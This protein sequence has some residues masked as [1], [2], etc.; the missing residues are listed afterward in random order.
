MQRRQQLYPTLTA[1][2]ALRGSTLKALAIDGVD[3]VDPP[4]PSYNGGHGLMN[5]RTSVERLN[6]D[7]Q[8]GRGSLVKEFSLAVG[9]SVSWIS[10]SV[11]GASLQTY[12]LVWSDP[13]GPARALSS[14]TAPDPQD[15]ILVNNINLQVEHV[16][17]GTVFHPW[18]LNP[19]LTGRTAALRSAAAVRAIDQRNN[20]ERITIPT[21][22]AGRY[23]ITVTHAGNP[24]GVPGAHP[25]P[26]P[27]VVSLVMSGTKPE[28]P[29][30]ISLVKSAPATEWMLN[31]TADPGAVFTIQTSTDLQT[32]SNTGTV[33]AAAVSNSVLVTSAGG[34]KRFWRLR[35]GQ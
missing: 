4:G 23:R 21:S 30:I 29:K 11:P 24:A 7:H 31:F 15:V 9:Q 16:E 2:D 3:D 13:Q 32:W 26:S 27:Q 18:T 34:V 5:A 33:M 20:V 14:L 28:L 1:A 25:A 19:D 17:T 22:S 12:T 10:E 6:Q 35:R 8:V